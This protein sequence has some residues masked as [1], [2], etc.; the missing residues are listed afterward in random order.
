MDTKKPR[1]KLTVIIRDD[2][3]MLTCGD[4]PSYRSVGIP[5][6]D[7]QLALL[8]LRHTCTISGEDYTEQISNCFLE[9]E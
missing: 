6:T 4:S 9:R 5:L 1:Y 8:K 7:E 3:P 2:S